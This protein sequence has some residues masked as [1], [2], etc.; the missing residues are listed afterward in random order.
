M[1]GIAVYTGEAVSR[2]LS[3]QTR[4]VSAPNVHPQPLPLATA[5]FSFNDSTT[6]DLI[7][8][9]YPYFFFDPGGGGPVK[10]CEGSR[11]RFMKGF[12]GYFFDQPPCVGFILPV[13]AQVS[14]LPYRRLL[15]CRPQSKKEQPESS[16]IKV[17][18]AKSSFPF[19][20][21][22]FPGSPSLS[23]PRALICCQPPLP[24]PK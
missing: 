9:F 8:A 23:P 11:E 17:N 14:N 13:V 24:H 3:R 5:R 6:H 1:N 4:F 19:S 12:E 22:L 21:S 7:T 16:Q 2:S 10:G 18:Q 15:A 20:S